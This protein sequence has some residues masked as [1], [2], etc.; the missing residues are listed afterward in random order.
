[1]KARIRDYN[2]VRDYKKLIEIIENEGQ[3]WKEYLDIKYKKNLEQS[4]TY[5]AYVNEELCGYVRSLNDSG[6]FI[7]VIDL[8]VDKKFRGN[9]IGKNLL[10]RIQFEFPNQD[11][12]VLSDADE[13]YEKLGYHR[14]GSIYQKK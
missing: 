8:L 7:W 3:D 6:L 5:V 4:I 12:F 11:I 1:M 2:K 14:E 9:S 10:D 13:Y